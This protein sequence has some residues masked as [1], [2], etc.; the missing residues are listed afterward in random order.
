MKSVFSFLALA[1]TFLI[2]EKEV[3][4]APLATALDPKT[5]QFQYH[6]QS[7]DPYI[8][9]VK[10][11]SAMGRNIV[12]TELISIKITGDTQEVSGSNI[13]LAL[14]GRLEN[15]VLI[16]RRDNAGVRDFSLVPFERAPIKSVYL[17]FRGRTKFTRIEVIVE[18]GAPL[19]NTLK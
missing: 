17:L 5:I 1:C 12:G 6:P 11:L 19:A 13:F 4:A 7:G 3:L 14:N 9:V 18:T 8:D 2:S 15:S 10:T 16:A